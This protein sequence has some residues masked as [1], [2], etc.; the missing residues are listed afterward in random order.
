[1]TVSTYLGTSDLIVH[2]LECITD[3]MTIRAPDMID[4]VLL[5][6]AASRLALSFCFTRVLMRACAV[7][8]RGARWLQRL[9]GPMT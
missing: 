4:L 5:A 9:A 8:R 6:G 1:M 2:T 3:T 7:P